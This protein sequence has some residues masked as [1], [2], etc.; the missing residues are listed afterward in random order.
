MAHVFFEAATH[1]L[2]NPNHQGVKRDIGELLSCSKYLDDLGQEDAAEYDDE[3]PTQ[4]DID[5]IDDGPLQDE[6]SDNEETDDEGTQ[7]GEV[8]EN[9]EDEEQAPSLVEEEIMSDD[10]TNT[11]SLAR[12]T[13]PRSAKRNKRKTKAISKCVT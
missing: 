4:S 11:E 8:D 3:E 5:F 1:W 2:N 7:D 10:A 9:P 12:S 13:P 6:E